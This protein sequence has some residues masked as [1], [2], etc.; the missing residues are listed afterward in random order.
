MNNNP[1]FTMTRGYTVIKFFNYK[2]EKEVQILASFIDLDK[3]L[4]FMNNTANTEKSPNE[5]LYIDQMKQSDII[6]EVF[7]KFNNIRWNPLNTIFVGLSYD[8]ESHLD[9]TETKN[10][11]FKINFKRGW[12]YALF[13]TEIC[14]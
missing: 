4:E 1:K 5:T 13:E 10:E 7:S 11:E 12:V 2:K 8:E 9:E 14:L 6:T 3:A